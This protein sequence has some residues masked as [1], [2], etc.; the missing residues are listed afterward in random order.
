MV[1]SIMFGVWVAFV[2]GLAVAQ[3]NVAA[4]LHPEKLGPYPVGVTTLVLVDHS[5]QDEVTKG[6]R[7]LLTDVWYPA[8]DDSRS[9]PK[10]TM[11]D[12]LLRGQ[13]PSIL[14]AFRAGFKVKVDDLDSRYKNEAIRDARMRDGKFPL[15]VFSHGNGG[16]RFQSTFWCDHLASHG[17]V[18]IACDHT[19]NSA[20][21][22]VGGKIILHDSKSREQHAAD[23]PKDVSYLIDCMTRFH[24][25]E[26]SRFAGRIRLDQIAVG[27]HSFGGYTCNEVISV[28]DRVK[29]IIP[30]T[31]VFRER[32]KFD[33]PLLL[34]V[35]TEDATIKSAGNENAR[36]YYEES[37]G[38]KYLV[39]I[40]DA[41][42]FSFSDMG[43]FRPDFGDGVGEGKRITR[44]EEPIKYLSLP[45]TYEITNAYS[46]A[47]LGR[48]LQGQKEWEPYLKV[49][50]YP[51]EVEFKSSDPAPV[52]T[53]P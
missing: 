23:R 8:T 47:F 46:V 2:P 50:H 48:Y 12:F 26:D 5:R 7:T 39:E 24:R 1:R 36:K 43:Q 11:T 33:V 25:G 16:L 28:D 37:T 19:G 10:N 29:A 31:P 22:V 44:P 32:K 20:A 6:P 34:F 35:A 41:G 14:L 45:R 40:K 17:Y 51:D 42:H 49:N 4:S 30:M 9:L 18:V 27:G 38:P 13:A 3:E 52:A 15:V 53:A 21:T